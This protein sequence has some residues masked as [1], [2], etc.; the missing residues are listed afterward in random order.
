MIEV[1]ERME[2]SAEAATILE[3]ARYL[4]DRVERRDGIP[5]A[6]LHRL[7]DTQG[8]AAANSICPTG[9]LKQATLLRRSFI[10]L[11]QRQATSSILEGPFPTILAV[12]L[13]TRS[14]R[15][16]DRARI[17]SAIVQCINANETPALLSLRDCA[18]LCRLL[19]RRAL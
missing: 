6:Y 3:H 16:T 17:H 10:F 9:I 8:W 5:T 7:A 2:G 19:A 4:V 15:H 13:N 1:L 14:L 12:C 18:A 11:E